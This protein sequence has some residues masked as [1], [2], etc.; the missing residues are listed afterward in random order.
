LDY[1]HL[2]EPLYAFANLLYPTTP[3]QAQAWVAPKLN[4]CLTDR[5]RNMLGALKRMRPRQ[6]AVGEALRQRIGYVLKGDR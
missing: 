3:A 5:V 1:Y 2:S 6:P 4:A